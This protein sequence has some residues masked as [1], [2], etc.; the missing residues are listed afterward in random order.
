MDLQNH[1][2]LTRREAIIHVSML[3]GSLSVLGGWARAS[4][5]ETPKKTPADDLIA[6]TCY[7]NS[8]VALAG[9]QL[10]YKSAGILEDGVLPSSDAM[11]HHHKQI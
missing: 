4:D 3:G 9:R 2:P 6:G 5:L 7:V 11:H 8:A 1:S 10:V